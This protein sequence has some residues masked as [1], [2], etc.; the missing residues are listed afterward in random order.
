MTAARDRH[1]VE[2]FREMENSESAGLTEIGMLVT[3]TLQF[4]VEAQAGHHKFET[5]SGQSD[6]SG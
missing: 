4:R 2:T 1:G 3:L 5:H 6:S